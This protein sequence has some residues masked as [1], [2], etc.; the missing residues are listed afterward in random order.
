MLSIA[1]A[2]LDAGRGEGPQLFEKPPAFVFAQ[3]LEKAPGF[4]G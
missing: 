1:V 4:L 2:V 3:G